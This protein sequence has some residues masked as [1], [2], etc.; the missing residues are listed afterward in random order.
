MCTVIPTDGNTSVSCSETC[1]S[2]SQYTANLNCFIV[3]IVA[4]VPILLFSSNII[5]Y[6]A[7]LKL[8]ALDL[9]NCKKKVT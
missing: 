3:Y 6:K 9:I 4:N 5:F 8:R 7:A 1:V 2:P